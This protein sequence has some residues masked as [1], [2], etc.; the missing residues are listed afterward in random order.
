MKAMTNQQ[1]L[2]EIH[3]RVNAW[4][5]Q[6]KDKNLPMNELL[7]DPEL[8]DI[9]EE[10]M[11]MDMDDLMV[12]IGRSLQEADVAPDWLNDLPDNDA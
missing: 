4:S 3:A 12:L 8:A 11:E 10:L 1:R 2:D 6:A 7:Q 5:E 9:I